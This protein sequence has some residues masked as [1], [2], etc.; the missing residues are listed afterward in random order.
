MVASLA[1]GIIATT[2]W[3]NTYKLPACVPASDC[4]GQT[5]EA[6]AECV[7]ETLAPRSAGVPEHEELAH[8]AAAS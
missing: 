7:W 6:V 5:R 8:L 3:Q 4:L 2:G 1:V